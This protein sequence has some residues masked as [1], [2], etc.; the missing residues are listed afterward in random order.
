MILGTNLDVNKNQIQNAAMHPV[1]TSPSSPVLAQFYTDTATS[2][3][4]P[5]MWLNVSG[6]PQWVSLLTSASGSLSGTGT[7]NSLTYWTGTSTLG[8][9]TAANYGVLVTNGSGVPS[10]LAGATGVLVG[11]ASAAPTF[12]N[13]PSLLGTNF[14]SIPNTAL[15]NSSVTIGSTSVA[16]GATVTTVAG[17]TLTAPT[18]G[19]SASISSGASLNVPSGAS[20]TVASGATFQTSTTPSAASDVVN[21]GYVDALIQ[22][23]APKGTARAATT[24]S[25]TTQTGTVP[26]YNNGTSGVGATL[27]NAGTKAALVIDGVSVAI[28]DLVLIKDEANYT[29][30]LYTVTTV[31]SGAVNWVLTRSTALDIS[32]EFVGAYIVVDLEGTTNKNSFWLCTNI[33]APTVGG[34][35]ITFTQLNGATS[36]VQ[37]SGITISGNTISLTSNSVTL[38]STSLTLGGTITTVAGLTSVTSTTFVGALTGNASSAT[39]ATN[40]TNIGITEDTATA[41]PVYPTW[42]TANTGN[43]PQK[44]TSTKLSF[45]PSTGVLSAT[46]FTGSGAGLTSIPNT[47]LTNSSITIGSTVVSLGT[48]A[49]TIAGLTSVTS[50]TFVGALTGNATTATTATNLPGGLLGSI[51]YQSGVGATTLLAGNTTTTLKVLTQVGNGSISAAPAWTDALTAGIARK[52]STTITGAGPTWVVTHN[53]GT[54]AVTVAVLDASNNAMIV[55]WQ[56]TSTNTI[57]LTYG[58]GVPN[59]GT[60]TVVVTG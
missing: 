48:T 7:A 31:G 19:G 25:F 51:H 42:V 55:D 32:T 1:G 58:Y 4:I 12:S 50:T 41:T 29:N 18:I 39:N 49:T 56:A 24:Q 16:L 60:H 54:Q 37:G 14:T 53:L 28:N 21:K 10:L 38:G 57:T 27:T 59:A 34:T 13:A 45:I 40:A 52:Y 20:L 3:H 30:G 11:S 9:V 17:L 8:T 23:Q 15:S 22:G 43:L 44:T 5:K 26:T 2:T 6:T 35:T 33:N 46:Q 36:L 47:A